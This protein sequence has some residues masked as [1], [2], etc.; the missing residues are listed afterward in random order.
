MTQK[1]NV[2]RPLEPAEPRREKVKL[3]GQKKGTDSFPPIRERENPL[4][5]VSEWPS[6]YFTPGLSLWSYLMQTSEVSLHVVVWQT[7]SFNSDIAP[8]SER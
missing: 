4:D 8:V 1:S 2:E 7:T 6:P 3:Q 5:T